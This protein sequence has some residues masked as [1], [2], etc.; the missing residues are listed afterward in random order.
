MGKGERCEG[1]EGYG[2]RTNRLD[3]ARERGN[4]TRRE[5]VEVKSGGGGGEEM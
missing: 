1:G 3:G 5:R 4:R 2:P